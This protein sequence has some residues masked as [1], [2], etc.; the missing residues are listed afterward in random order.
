M[1]A[2]GFLNR[3]L[4]IYANTHNDLLI[5][6]SSPNPLYDA[7]RE[8][9]LDEKWKLEWQA[10]N[11]SCQCPPRENAL[12]PS[13]T[14]MTSFFL[15]YPN[16]TVEDVAATL[17]AAANAWG[18]FPPYKEMD[19]DPI[20]LHTRIKNFK[21]AS[22]GW[23]YIIVARYE[24]IG[25]ASGKFV[26]MCMPCKTPRA[27][28]GISKRILDENADWIDYSEAVY[29][30]ATTDVTSYDSFKTFKRYLNLTPP[31]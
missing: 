10:Q 13:Q 19:L 6:T 21:K 29:E 7:E 25:K 1:I 22:F 17:E 31:K 5:L 30:F 3:Q 18:K 28:M 8:F 14:S 24:T 15:E 16:Y 4:D 12:T 26:A 23:R 2:D 11:G 27:W 20:Q 9:A